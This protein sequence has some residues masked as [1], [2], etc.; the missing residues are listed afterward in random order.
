[1]KTRLPAG[2]QVFTGKTTVSEM[3]VFFNRLTRPA[4]SIAEEKVVWYKKSHI[5][6]DIKKYRNVRS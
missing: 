4:P 5:T 2:R 6:S 1:L 3:K